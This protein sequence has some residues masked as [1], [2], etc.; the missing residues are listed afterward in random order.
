METF[1]ELKDF[2]ENP[3]FTEQRER[4]LA[5]LDLSSI[6]VPIV[7]IIS[8]FAKLPYCF[9]LQSCYGHFLYP[10]QQNANNYKPLPIVDNIKRVEYRIAYIAL[11]LENNDHGRA[12]LQ[13]LSKIPPIDPDYIQI[14]CADWFWKRQVN[15]FVLQVE[16]YRH[17]YKDRVSVDYL[18][19]RRIENTRYDFFAYLYTLLYERQ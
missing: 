8:F 4:A 6:D 13:D 7:H 11:C 17:R 18:E 10:G 9:T 16:P 5:N 19:A 3:G 1:T 15:S 2:V 14:G 12:L